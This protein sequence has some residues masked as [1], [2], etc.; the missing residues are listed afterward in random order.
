MPPFAEPDRSIEFDASA[1]CIDRFSY[2]C[3]SHTT[4]QTFLKHDFVVTASRHVQHA[5]I[6]RHCD[7]IVASEVPTVVNGILHAR[8]NCAS[9]TSSEVTSLNE[10]GLSNSCSVFAPTSAIRAVDISILWKSVL[11]TRISNVLSSGAFKSR[12][13]GSYNTLPSTIDVA[14]PRSSPAPA[15]KYSLRSCR[16]VIVR[17]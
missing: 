16:C 17:Q 4:T 2:K 11:F 9:V 5:V 8:T 1:T 14:T 3:A 12:C 15:I 10:D 7:G 6:Y 13:S